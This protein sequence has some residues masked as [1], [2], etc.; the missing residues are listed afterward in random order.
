MEQHRHDEQ[1]AGNQYK[2]L[3]GDLRGVDQ[4][5]HDLLELLRPSKILF[6]T[7]F[8]THARLRVV[9]FEP[10]NI[11]KLH[12]IKACATHKNTVNIGFLHDL[13]HVGC[14]H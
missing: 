14:F 1:D 3:Q 13:S 12:R 5:R 8:G 4:T 11:S 2:D 7:T 6:Q 10:S 9:L